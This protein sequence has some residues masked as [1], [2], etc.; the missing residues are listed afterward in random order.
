MSRN[1]FIDLVNEFCALAKLE[2]PAL[3][4]EGSAIQVDGVDFIIQ[5]DEEQAP[6]HVLFYCDFGFPPQQ[7]LLEAYEAL[8]ET[9]MVIYGPSSPSFMLGPD[10]RVTFGYQS[11]L[12][13]VRAGD[14]MALFSNLAEQAKDWRGDYFLGAPQPA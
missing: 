13:D 2:Q 5:Y 3:L 11:R 14:L 8:L 9:N 6:E 10:K 12:A 1:R 4:V 7:R